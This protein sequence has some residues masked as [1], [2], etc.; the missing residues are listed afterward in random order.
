M[1]FSGGLGI[2][3]SISYIDTTIIIPNWNGKKWLSPCLMALKNQTKNNFITLIIDNGSEDE[4]ITFIQKNFPWVQIISLP[5]NRGFA[6]AVNIGIKAA[7]TPFIILLNTDTIPD[8][9]WFS[10]L[11]TNINTA[12]PDVASLSSCMVMMENPK[13]IDDAGDSFSWFGSAMKRGN[14]ENVKLY[15]KG[16][17]IFSSCAGAAL[18]RRE[19][20]KRIGLFDETFGSY[21][22]DV[23]IGLRLRLYGYRNFYVPQAVVRHQGHGSEIKKKT[24]IILMTKNRMLLF[25]KN[26]PLSILIKKSPYIIAGQLWYLMAYKNPFASFTGYFLLCLVMPHIIIEHKN[27]RKNQKVTNDFLEKLIT[28]DKPE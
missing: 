26:I 13:L 9:G 16:G 19:A 4:S 12:P 28:T 7:K 6:S 25:L 11:H 2:E 24:Y 10:A 5:K 18:Y 23:D 14:K 22:E 8:P 21:L 3:M 15:L 1:E 20:I 17:E 27:I